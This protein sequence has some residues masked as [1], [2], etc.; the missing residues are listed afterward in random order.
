MPKDRL[1]RI[2][3]ICKSNECGD[4]GKCPFWWDDA[5]G[6]GYCPFDEGCPLTWNLA[7]IDKT[8][9]EVGDD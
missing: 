1:E 8:L 2:K 6:F 5:Q 4:E 7:R 3:E 9:E